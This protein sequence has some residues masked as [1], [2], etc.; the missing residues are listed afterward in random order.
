[1]VALH[2]THLLICHV[3]GTGITVCLR[4]PRICAICARVGASTWSE[5]ANE[6]ERVGRQVGADRRL[7]AKPLKVFSLRLKRNGW[8]EAPLFL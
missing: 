7:S 6:H 1:M 8:E 2:A 4:L 3:A 5:P